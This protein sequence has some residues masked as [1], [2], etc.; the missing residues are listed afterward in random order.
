[1]MRQTVLAIALACTIGAAA[2]QGAAPPLPAPNGPTGG[3]PAPPTPVAAT[4]VSVSGTVERFMLNPNGD[5]DGLWL[6]DGTQVGFPPHLSSDVKAAVRA[7]DNVVVQ[8]FRLGNLPV[9]QLSSIRSGRSGREVVDR[10]PT[11]GP[12]PPPTPGQLTPLQADGKIQRL[13]YGPAGEVNG[14]LVSD[15]TV[16]RMPP[17][18]ALQFADLLGVGA[19][20]SASGFGVATPDGRAMEATQLGRD[21]SSLR[22]LFPAPRPDGPLPPPPPGA[23]V[24]P[25]G[26]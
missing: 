15:G 20:L 16:V 2:A 5:V 8:G 12:P 19:P 22:P 24:L 14:A 11:F 7:G 26:G 21:R 13:V 3:P 25:A 9:L 18:L 23:P 17:H 1:M 10:P 6:R 4:P